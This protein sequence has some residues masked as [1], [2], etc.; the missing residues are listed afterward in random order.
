MYRRLSPKRE[1]ERKLRLEAMRRGKDRARMAREPE[2]RAP[3][4]P[5]LR[6]EVVVIDYDSGE[7]VTLC[8]LG[9]VVSQGGDSLGGIG[10]CRAH[11]QLLATGNDYQCQQPP[12]PTGYT[13]QQSDHS[14]TSPMAL[15]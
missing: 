7:P 11:P 5:L 13:F 15:A 2:G 12:R 4:L 6:R 9:F 1:A 3:D 10:L 8:N 14:I